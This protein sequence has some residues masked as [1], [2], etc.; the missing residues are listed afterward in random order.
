MQGK[1]TIK[2]L[3]F[4]GFSTSLSSSIKLT[5]MLF[6]KRQCSWF[7][8]NF[9]LAAQDKRRSSAPKSHFGAAKL[10]LI[11]KEI[12]EFACLPWLVEDYVH[13]LCRASRLGNLKATFHA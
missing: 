9:F 4:L 13:F 12:P 7:S 1:P 8:L 5:V 11:Q 2:F 6:P 10:L 3:H